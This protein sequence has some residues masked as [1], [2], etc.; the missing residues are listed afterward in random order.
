MLVK[1]DILERM[2]VEQF[3]KALVLEPS[4]G[5]SVAARAWTGIRDAVDDRLSAPEI[6]ADALSAALSGKT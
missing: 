6:V 3:W 4:H 2:D 5:L 1:L